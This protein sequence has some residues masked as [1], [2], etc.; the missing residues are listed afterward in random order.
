MTR[1][2]FSVARDN[3]HALVAND[4]LGVCVCLGGPVGLLND[5]RSGSIS[6]SD[7]GSGRKRDRN[8]RKGKQPE[9]AD[10]RIELGFPI[11]LPFSSQGRPNPAALGRSGGRGVDFPTAKVARSAGTGENGIFQSHQG[12]NLP[13]FLSPAMVARPGR[14]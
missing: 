9:N 2:T 7:Y 12:A 4:D 8:N 3:R 13:S 10:L 5:Q 11:W 6:R 1:Q 14:S